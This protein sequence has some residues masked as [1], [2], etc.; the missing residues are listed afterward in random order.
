MREFVLDP[1]YRFRGWLKT[2]VKHAVA[3]FLRKRG[4][5]PPMTSLDDPGVGQNPHE[6]GLMHA[7]GAVAEAVEE[8]VRI[9]ERVRQQVNPDHWQAFYLT[10]VESEPACDVATKLGMTK[11]AVYTARHRV[12]KLLRAEGAKGRA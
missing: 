9:A 3:D 4:R 8:G 2:V 7:V 6:C 12:E 10:A 11:A 5:E 1:Q